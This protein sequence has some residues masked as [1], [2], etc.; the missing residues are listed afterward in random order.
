MAAK[1]R[2]D[3]TDRKQ[4]SNE[5]AAMSD[6]INP[7]HY[8]RG[9]VECIDVTESLNFCLGNAFKY[10][11]RFRDKGRPL[12]DLG[13][14]CWYLDREMSARASSE[15]WR[16]FPLD[17]RYEISSQGRVRMKGK[18][19]R[20]L[21][22]LKNGYLTFVVS[23]PEG[24]KCY[25]AHRAV[26]EAFLD[27]DP[28]LEVCHL[29]GT[30]TNNS[31]WNLR[32]GTTKAN[33]S[34]KHI[35]GTDYKGG[36]NPSAK[37][38]ANQVLTIRALEGC[39][40]CAEIG[41]RFG[42]SAMTIQRIWSGVAWSEIPSGPIGALAA[43]V[44]GEADPDVAAALE[45]IAIAQWSSDGIEDVKKARWYLERLLAHLGNVQEAQ[46]GQQNT[47]DCRTD[48]EKAELA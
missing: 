34:H 17:C 45:L 15:E 3:T 29:D 24:N 18:N 14:A 33:H 40:T 31:V 27:F 38:S 42:V 6:A 2:P 26:A 16:E 9:S 28:S 10:V 7:T 46:F 47:I 22:P 5:E 44:E 37:L 1:A 39:G 35:H 20:K 11:F 8:T 48:A 43:I 32:Q 12:E 25:Y 30:R 23:S 13:K 41:S 36:D 4:Q 19:P 21:V